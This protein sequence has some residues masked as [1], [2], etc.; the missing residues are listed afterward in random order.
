MCDCDDE[1]LF[2]DS[3]N[4]GVLRA[5]S[6]ANGRGH[7]RSKWKRKNDSVEESEECTGEVWPGRQDLCH[8]SESNAQDS[9]NLY[10]KYCCENGIQSYTVCVYCSQSLSNRMEVSS[11]LFFKQK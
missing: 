4:T 6:S 7:C 8:E 2:A 10:S 9:G 1:A 11:N 5:D 3:K